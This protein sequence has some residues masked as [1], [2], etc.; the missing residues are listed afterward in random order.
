MGKKSFYTVDEAAE[1][2]GKSP[3]EV[4]E[5]SFQQFRNG[6]QVMFKAAEVDA[7]AGGG[8]GDSGGLELDD[9][10]GSAD[11]NQTVEL[12][13]GGSDPGGFGQTLELDD[14]LGGSGS[15]PSLGGSDFGTAGGSGSGSGQV[16]V[17][18][19]DEV[20]SADPSA[21]TRVAGP[22]PGTMDEEELVLEAVGSGSGLLD[23]TRESD[24]TSLGAELLDEIYPAGGTGTGM[25]V[26]PT[27]ASMASGFGDIFDAGDSEAGTSGTM[28]SGM[29]DSGFTEAGVETAAPVGYDMAA[30]APVEQIDLAGS[31]LMFGFLM[32]AFIA[33]ALTSSIM[34][35]TLGDLE[36][37]LL[38]HVSE[39][40]MVYLV[41][42][43]ACSLVFGIAGYFIGRM[44][45]K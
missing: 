11:V 18:D 39:Q 6:D 35:M 23:L 14:P 20:I 28:G 29:G 24:D 26:E 43:S 8:S 4:L 27:E 7:A 5:M 36:S 25:S 32:P 40:W 45:D 9:D 16:S 44:M 17:F 13:P 21:Q 34:M 10:F 1:L 22:D 38:I 19:D 33:L 42:L 3:E 31:G 2:L 12:D 37:P 15:G 30:Y 41:V